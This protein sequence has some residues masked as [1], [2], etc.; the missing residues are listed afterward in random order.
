MKILLDMG[1]CLSGADTGAIG[2]GRK[3]QDC[4]REIGEKVKSKLESLGH[5]VIICSC[6][7]AN[8]LGESLAY[9]VNKANKNGGDLYISI[10]LNAGGGYGIEIFTY[11]GKPFIE[12]TRTL[13]SFVALGLKNRGI[14]DGSDLY[15]IKNTAMESMLVECCFMDTNDMD[16]YNAESFTNAIV[17]GITGQVASVPTSVIVQPIVPIDYWVAR[18]Q[19]TIGANADNIPGPQTLSLCPLVKPGMISNVV[20]LL[21]E[22][23]KVGS[24]GIFGPQ[25]LR[26]VKDFQSKNGLVADGIV[27]KNTWSKLL[28]L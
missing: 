11:G 5:T 16:K 23:L 10:H 20:K 9:R 25:T 3:E 24:D 1:H 13:E 7:N 2:N 28:N 8:S 12:A 4:T 17:K 21:Q 26:V 18:L 19:S 6:D 27:G 14:K 15:V 22:K